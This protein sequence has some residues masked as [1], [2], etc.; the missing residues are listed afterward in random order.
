MPA[1]TEILPVVAVALADDQGRFLMQQRPA[2]KAHAGLW[3]FPGGKVE[4]GETPEEA[5]CRELA[6]ELGIHVMPD[7]LS[8]FAF[9]SEPAGGG[10]H[11]ILMLYLCR[12]WAGTP[13]AIEAAALCWEAPAALAA[14]PMPPAD[15]VLVEALKERAI[16]TICSTQPLTA[17][18][19]PESAAS[20]S[21]GLRDG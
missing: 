16:S 19:P 15:V 6:E 13:H 18:P 21:S 8:P 3:E 12:R 4:R 11:L 1:L 5:L 10:R 7:D 2:G 14:L 9:A 20:R 17:S